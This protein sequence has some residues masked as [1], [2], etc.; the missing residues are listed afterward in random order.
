MTATTP[1]GSERPLPSPT[2]SQLT[3]SFFDA[4]DIQSLIS[5]S[6]EATYGIYPINEVYLIFIIKTHI[7]L[8]NNTFICLKIF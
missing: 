4:P 7:F 6:S 2:A 3:K 8:T 5:L 1:T